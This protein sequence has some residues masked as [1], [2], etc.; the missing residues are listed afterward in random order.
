M[1]SHAALCHHRNALVPI[2]RGV[3]IHRVPQALDIFG[4]RAD[5]HFAQRGFDDVNAGRTAPANAVSAQAIVCID[6]A[7]EFVRVCRAIPAAHGSH[8]VALRGVV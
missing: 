2:R 8:G 5:E 3:A 1:P 4:I 7:R 6:P